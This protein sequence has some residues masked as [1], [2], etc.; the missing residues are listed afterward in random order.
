MYSGKRKKELGKFTIRIAPEVQT[1]C[2][3]LNIVVYNVR[4][5]KINKT[6]M[7]FRT[8]WNEF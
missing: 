4:E 6:G 3:M 5:M 7:M 1:I 2:R 8:E